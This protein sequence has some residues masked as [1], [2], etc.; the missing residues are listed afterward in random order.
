MRQWVVWI[1]D[2]GLKSAVELN[3]GVESFHD[4]SH[5]ATCPGLPIPQRRAN[6][7]YDGMA[8]RSDDA[9]LRPNA[10]RESI[11]ALEGLQVVLSPYLQQSDH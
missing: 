2:F 11:G 5:R 4:I 10:M 7:L 8:A 9:V 1:C 6:G 3:F